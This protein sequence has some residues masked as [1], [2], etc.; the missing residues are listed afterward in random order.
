MKNVTL[1]T[2]LSL[3]AFGLVGFLYIYSRMQCVEMDY[4]TNEVRKDVEKINLVNKELKAKKAKMLS[5][6]NLRSFATKYDLKVPKHE[7]I[8]VIQ[9]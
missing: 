9:D 5:V 6:K 4:A 3:V 8:I 7:Q 1:R 2:T